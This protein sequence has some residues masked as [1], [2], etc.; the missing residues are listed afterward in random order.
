MCLL[1]FAWNAHPHYRLVFAGNR[2]EFHERPTAPMAWW[3]ESDAPDGRIDPAAG[4]ILAGRDLKAGG[5]WLGLSRNGRFGVVTN[6]R[7]LQKA[8]PNAPSRGELITR[9]LA[10]DVSAQQF[11]DGLAPDAAG[12]AGFN[13]LLADA[14]GM[15]YL[16]NRALALS[17]ALPSGIYGLSNHFLD[18]PWPK[19]ERTRERFKSLMSAP[20]P[21]PDALLAML[22]DRE[23]TR[24]HLLPE[25]G[26]SREWELLL[27]SPFIVDER[28]GTRCST[29]VMIRHDGQV[30]ARER[31]FDAA[32]RSTAMDEFTFAIPS[33]S[34]NA[35]PA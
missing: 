18:T 4:G 2:D 16:S 35:M 19:L 25:T 33:R 30:L 10:R 20:D 26:L 27:S 22:N 11:S 28:Y 3:N 15:V 5:T 34:P 14:N 13:L 23:P 29:V 12:Y 1:V 24:E 6:F 32:G 7:D 9:F 31:R 17:R 21:S 8:E